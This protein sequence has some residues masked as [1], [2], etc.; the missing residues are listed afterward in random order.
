MDGIVVTKSF[1]NEARRLGLDQD[2]KIQAQI[3]LAVERALAIARM[4]QFINQ[5]KADVAKMN[6]ETRAQEW[7]T[8]P[9]LMLTKSTPK[10][11]AEHVL[12]DTKKR[13]KKKL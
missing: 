12:I 4:E 3:K 11:E 1:A 8:K 7:P 10:F 13:S 6:M 2:P 5:A 9:S